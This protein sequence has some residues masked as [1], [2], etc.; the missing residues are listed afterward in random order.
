MSD[1]SRSVKP[2]PLEDA[3]RLRELDVAVV[4]HLPVVAP[5]VEEVVPTDHLRAGL[6][7]PLH[8]CLLVVDHEA[9]VASTVRRLRPA[10][11][12]RDE[13]VAE[14]DEGHVPAAS[15]QRQLP[16]DRLEERE[17]L[18]DRAYLDGDVV[19]ADRLRH[20]TSVATAV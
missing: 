12:E 15:A 16:E 5:R 6:A 7:R 3:R 2:H 19:D 1:F 10:C 9:D 13:L 20:G 17:R 8:C 4:D 11:L 18:V 14:I